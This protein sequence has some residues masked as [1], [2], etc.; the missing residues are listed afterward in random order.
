MLFMS[1]VSSNFV[2]RVQVS[3]M[4]FLR[5]FIMFIYYLWDNS[6][7]EETMQ[8]HSVGIDRE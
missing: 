7:T 5:I 4:S 3:N 8:Q 6:S 1:S 2:P